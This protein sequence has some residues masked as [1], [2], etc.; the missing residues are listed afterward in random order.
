MNST[1]RCF[2]RSLSRT[3]N[4]TKS[5]TSSMLPSLKQTHEQFNKGLCSTGGFIG[6]SNFNYLR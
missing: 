4:P 2:S 5:P 6:K 1:T 3:R